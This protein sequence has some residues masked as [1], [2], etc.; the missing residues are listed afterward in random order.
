[1]S[2]SVDVNEC[3]VY[4][5]LCKGGGYCENQEGSFRCLCPDG[6][7]LDSTG[8]QCVGKLTTHK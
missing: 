4:P 7:S 3:E 6:L 5:D 1:M 2:V 8:T